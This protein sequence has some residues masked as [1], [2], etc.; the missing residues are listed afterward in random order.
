APAEPGAIIRTRARERADVA[1]DARPTQRRRG[2]AG[3]EGDGRSA[4]SRADDVKPLAVYVDDGAGRRKRARATARADSLIDRTG[5]EQN[6]EQE[7][8]GAR[9]RR[10]P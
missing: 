4:L 2:D 9:H 8:D 5:R 7:E 10:R 6:G 3:F 1:H